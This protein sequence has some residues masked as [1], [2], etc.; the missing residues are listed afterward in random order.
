MK[1]ASFACLSLLLLLCMCLTACTTPT[2]QSGWTPP[3]NYPSGGGDNGDNGG[4]DSGGEGDGDTPEVLENNT[5]FVNEICSKSTDAVTGSLDW[6]E[7]YNAGEEAVDLSGWWLSD[8]K[9]ELNRYVFPQGTSIAPASYLIVWASGGDLPPQGVANA[10]LYASFRL[11]NEGETVYLSNPDGLRADQLKFPGTSKNTTFGRSEDG[12]A[13]F[14]YLSGSLGRT[15]GGT[16]TG[17]AESVLT[18][19][20]ESGFYSEDF[21][22]SISAPEGYTVYYTVDC[23]DPKGENGVRYS[24]AITVSD[25]SG[26]PT[27]SYDFFS[28]K[29]SNG[30]VTDLSYVDKCFVVRAV[31]CDEEGHYTQTITKSYF[32]GY[33]AGEGYDTLPIIT[34]TTDPAQIYDKTDG[35]FYNYNVQDLEIQVNF[36]YFEAGGEY[37]FDQ[38]VGMQIRGSSTRG[39]LQKSLNLMARSEYGGDS[40]FPNKLF[41]DAAF[42]DSV[43]LRADNRSN[44]Q[45]GQGYLQTLIKDRN[46]VTQDYRPVI[47]FL[48]GEYYGLYNLYERNSDEFLEAHYGVAEDD[49]WYVKF[50]REPNCDAA[51]SAYTQMHDLLAYGNLA[52]ASTYEQLCE[53]VDMQSLIDLFCIYV[54][55]D[56][57]DFSMSQNIAAWR[58]SDSAIDPTN[59]YADGK[60]RFIIFDLDYCLD[61]P[62]QTSN[63][64]TRDTFSATPKN[65]A[66]G[67]PFLKF[68]E[69]ANL[70]KNGTFREDFVDT[71][72]YLCNHNF[73]FETR[74]SAIVEEQ[75]DILLPAIQP[76]LNRFNNLSSSG[77]ERN[78]SGWESRLREKQIR[79]LKYRQDYII[80]YLFNHFDV[81]DSLAVVTVQIPDAAEKILL[82]G[83]T[84]TPTDS[85]ESLKLHCQAGDTVTVK[86][87]LPAGCT[88]SFSLT[89]CTQVSRGENEITFRVV[90][91]GATVNVTVN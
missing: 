2:T 60:W 64:W 16:V 33:E 66:I 45:L 89:G 91:D 90:A 39:S 37:S 11:S 65:G 69:V 55:Y 73:Q 68:T 6:I 81:E 78:P 3:D 82:D 62:A 32:V 42:T 24:K 88:A 74:V 84:L 87:E 10:N 57:G 30:R 59:P 7:L 28:S 85:T 56:N 19:S 75:I 58:C 79:F 4:G 72:L 38:E 13:V 27:Y 25:P 49:V 40:L 36:S 21:Q 34:L 35:L 76:Y 5:V 17:L 80:D 86:L 1:R 83:F 44:L 22:L 54:Y 43:V 77:S 50:G 14:A 67:S 70:M 52:S 41:P 26:V 47:L 31:A 23:T 12:G 53:M 15:N 63:A 51:M 29:N 46:V 20:H 18:F 61:G 71:F 9:K 48:D 8:T